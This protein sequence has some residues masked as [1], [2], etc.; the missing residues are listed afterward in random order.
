MTEAETLPSPARIVLLA[1]HMRATELGK[2]FTT[3]RRHFLRS[4]IIRI[5]IMNRRRDHLLPSGLPDPGS[6]HVSAATTFIEQ[7]TPV[8]FNFAPL[9]NLTLLHGLVSPHPKFTNQ[10]A[11]E[12]LR[13][14]NAS[15]SS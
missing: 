2:S 15:K 5:V 4:T 8:D 6:C 7:G 14:N 13:T 9:H 12:Y 3:R 1:L 11:T 10:I